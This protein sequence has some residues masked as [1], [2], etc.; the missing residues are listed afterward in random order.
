MDQHYSTKCRNVMDRCYHDKQMLDAAD[1]EDGVAVAVAA[2]DVDVEMDGKIYHLLI[3]HVM[4]VAALA[5]HLS[6]EHRA[7][8]PEA[9]LSMGLTNMVM[10]WHSSSMQTIPNCIQESMIGDSDR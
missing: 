2:V 4:H 8:A 10:V 7:M 9:C 5:A 3:V 1:D 6:V